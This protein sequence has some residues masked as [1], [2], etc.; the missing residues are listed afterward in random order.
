MRK[1]VAYLLLAACVGV[2]VAENIV[3][4]RAG[5]MTRVLGDA[6]V[7]HVDL[8]TPGRLKLLDT[9]LN[10]KYDFDRREV[11]SITIDN[12]IPCADMLDV[13]FNSDGSAVDVSPMRNNIVN[14]DATT[15]YDNQMG[16]YVARFN[17]NTWGAGPANQW[18]SIDYTNNW[19]FRN[20]LADGHTIEA[21]VRA[22]FSASG[23]SDTEV[24]PFCSHQSG[25]TGFLL[26]TRNFTFLPNVST[27]GSNTWRWAKSSIVPVCGAYYHLVGVYDKSA[28]KARIYVNGV[29]EAECDAVGNFNFPVGS[30]CQFVI[31]GDTNGNGNSEAAWRGDI[32]VARIYSNPLSQ[33]QI[34][35]L[36]RGVRY[37]IDTYNHDSVLPKADL[38]DV[39]F[40]GDGTATDISAKHFNIERCNTSTYYNSDFGRYAAHFGNE[41]SKQA[42]SWFRMDY[43]SDQDFM[44]RL[45]D[46]HTLEAL[47]M[48][49]YD[50]P[51]VDEEAKPFSSHEK[52]GTGFLISRTSNGGGKNVMTFLPNVSTNGSSTWRWATSGEIPTPNAFYHLVGVYDKSAGKANIYVNGRLKGSVSVSGSMVFPAAVARR[53]TIGGD[54]NSN[55]GVDQGWRGDVVLAR[56]YDRALQPEDAYLLY[57]DVC[58]GVEANTP[59][60]MS[61]WLLE[62]IAAKGG[63]RLPIW[64]E[65]WKTG[66]VIVVTAPDNSVYQVATEIHGNHV[67][68]TLPQSLVSGVYKV[69]V[70]HGN[71][72]QL[73]GTCNVTA[74]STM[75]TGAKPVAHRGYW[76]PEGSAQNS[77]SSLRNAIALGTFGSECDVWMTTDK[78]MVINHDETLNGV[79]LYKNNYATVKNLRLS[80]GEGL[81]ALNEFLD[82]V[83]GTDTKLIIEVKTHATSANTQAAAA[84][85][86]ACVERRSMQSGV[87]FI[88]FDYGTCQYIAS[89][90]YPVQYLNGDKSPAEL[91]NGISLDYHYSKFQQ[92]P[93][94][95]AEAHSRGQVVNGWTI[96]SSADIAWFN[97]I[98]GDWLTTDLPEVA[99]KYYY[100]YHMNQ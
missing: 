10:I 99:V 28:A 80:N 58:T 49:D 87:A 16:R 46:G 54:P 45:A 1:S 13:V 36:Y 47:I 34:T 61:A 83:K 96:N 90:G 27:D 53:F 68:A 38:L 7:E 84:E 78:A 79:S 65:G 55:N 100:Y 76:T 29:L 22:D 63:A 6:T 26:S 82:I 66:D 88:A 20:A 74:V 15:V 73:L 9:E 85:A 25:G 48:A 60:I 91:D 14:H 31:G 71:F 56:I 98:G 4:H 50:Y 33:Q 35:A 97:R 42:E 81:P 30:V 64:G 23:L 44:N 12:I 32:A 51:L 67:I 52:G 86:I 17:N 5:T 89:R 59:H 72:T 70:K 95:I 57:R 92:N 24:K 94:W 62:D 75:P 40:N 41:W 11:D 21:V 19:D 43:S 2:A 18:Y 8:T 69:G 93:N 37:G 39:V 3:L 77:R